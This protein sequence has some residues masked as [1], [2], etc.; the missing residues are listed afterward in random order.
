MEKAVITLLDASIWIDF[1]RAR[2]PGYLKQFIAPYVLDPL[3]HL[4]EPVVFEVMRYALPKEIGPLTAQF[5]AV[6]M[7]PTPGDLWQRAA[8]LGQKCRNKGCTPDALDLLIAQVALS[9]DALVVTFDE[10][11]KEISESTGLRAK[12]L[13]RPRGGVS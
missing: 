8:I 11:F 2:S 1:T 3:A 12:V 13:Q 4:A 5:K 6:P 9:H 7:L 10:D